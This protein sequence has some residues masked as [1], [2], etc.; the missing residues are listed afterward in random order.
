MNR[1]EFFSFASAAD[2]SALTQMQVGGQ[3][4]SAGP[5]RQAFEYRLAFDVWIND[6][7]NEAVPLQNWPYG[8]L[9]D[10]TVDGIVRALDVQSE[11]GYTVVDLAGLWTTYSWPVDTDRVVDKDRRRRINR[12]IKAVHD[13]NM[14]IIC[15][16][17]GI[18]NWGFDEIIQANPAVRTD[19]KHE[20]NP[21]REESWAW[22]HKIFDYA[23][24]NYEIDGYHLEAADQGRCK[25]PAC[26]ARW[27]DNAAYFCF[28][29]GKM[30]KYIRQKY[31]NMTLIATI[32]G[33]R[34]WG[35]SFTGEEQTDLIELSQYLDCLF[36]QGHHGTY[37]PPGEWKEFIP[38]LRCAYGTS[39]GIW[40]YP[41]ERWPRTRWFLPYTQR[42]GEAMQELYRAGGRG[43]M[44][45]QGP[46]R[47]PG[48]EV[49]IAFGGRFMTHART[50]TEDTLAE[51]LEQLYR[52]ET[53]DAHRSLVE[54]FKSAENAYFG[55]WNKA[56][57]AKASGEPAPGNFHL[58][59]S[60]GASP[61]APFYLMEPYLDT[62][63][64]L[65]YKRALV[66]ILKRLSLIEN[67]FRDD[68]RIGRIKNGIEEALVDLNNI[69]VC[70]GERQV[71]DDEETG[72]HF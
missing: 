34:K 67:Q 2:G 54:I 22:M 29:T 41:N 50:D 57:I 71:W 19:N 3:N 47:N 36:D 70:K 28:V 4:R 18:L 48:I 11:F 20:M 31:P 68:G 49:N 69:A 21:L 63:G 10:K 66:S 25:T 32:Q 5:E 72:R 8:V 15:F 39:G 61:G 27:P 60:F 65:N 64:R 30:A 16:P 33:F 6:V 9:D 24:D 23:A 1:R 7:R 58:T 52:P 26:M 38:R 44:Y 43:V 42:T 12:I 59:N 53:R 17:S 55:Q 46:V 56:E 45:Y 40:I 51:V 14:K 35:H 37:I 13:R 62:R